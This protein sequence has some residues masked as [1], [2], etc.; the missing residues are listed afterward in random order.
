MGG[1]LVVVNYGGLSGAYARP[2][3]DPK[4]FSRL[5]DEALDHL[6]RE[7]VVAAKGTWRRVR[8]SSFSAGFGAVRE[9]LGVRDHFDRI[10]ALFMLDSIYAGYTGGPGRREVNPEHMKRWR[11]FAK[12]AAEG[13]KVFIITH[14]YLAPGKY[15]GTHETADDLVGCVD[16]ERREVNEEGPGGMKVIS[17]AS[18]G[19]FVVFG[20]RGTD[21]EAHMQHLRKMGGWIKK[22]RESA[23]T[24]PATQTAPGD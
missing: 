22:L 4:R 10:D 20:C 19:G 7:K 16:L 15:A 3:R 21:G 23:A 18:R 2:Y 8:I 5:L 14:S 12:A 1:V 11:R 17:R 6:R 13:K 9:I 24:R